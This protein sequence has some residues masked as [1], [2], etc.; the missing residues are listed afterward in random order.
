MRWVGFIFLALAMAGCASQPGGVSSVHQSHDYDDNSTAVVLAF[1]PP[2]IAGMP[3]LDLSRED[4]GTA[5]FVGFEDAR[6][7]YYSLTNDD[8]YSDFSGG[9]GGGRFGRFQGPDDYQRRA[10]SQTSGITTR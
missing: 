5:A 4:R 7:T 2:A 9:G 8:W 6:T 10:V 3:E 1:D